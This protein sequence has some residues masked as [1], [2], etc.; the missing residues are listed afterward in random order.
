[1]K[2]DEVFAC[3]VNLLENGAGPLGKLGCDI[4][5]C[6]KY[7]NKYVLQR[8]NDIEGTKVTGVTFWYFNGDT[9]P[10]ATVGAWPNAVLAR[11]LN[12]EEALIHEGYTYY[13]CPALDG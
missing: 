5:V 10:V 9:V 6:G 12:D 11:V 1:M 3:I 13:T 4:L 7:G 2:R 8:R